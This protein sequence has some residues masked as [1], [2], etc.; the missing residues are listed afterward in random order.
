MVNV[1]VDGRKFIAS[2][3][4]SNVDWIT[5]INKRRLTFDSNRSIFLSVVSGF[6][7]SKFEIVPRPEPNKRKSVFNM[8]F[9]FAFELRVV[10]CKVLRKTTS[11][12][13]C[14]NFLRFYWQNWLSQTGKANLSPLPINYRP[15][16]STQFGKD[17][18]DFAKTLH[19]H[20]RL[21]SP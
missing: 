18:F 19:F 21:G 3:K 11:F 16:P 10:N 5:A 8:A 9:P 4:V 2:K 7:E 6:N 20:S 12:K 17:D 13:G 15:Y 14:S 1:P